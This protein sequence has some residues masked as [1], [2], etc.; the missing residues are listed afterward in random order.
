METLLILYRLFLML[1]VLSGPQFLGV[2]AYRA[3]KKHDD[4]RAHLLGLLIPPVLF[5]CF[6]WV[7]LN[8]SIKSIEANGERACGT[9]AGMMSLGILFMTGL[10][11]VF[12]IA[13]QVALHE[14]HRTDKIP[15]QA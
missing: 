5:F 6:S 9:Y 8:S 10:Q 2:L 4:F 14:K 11:A 7:M 15:R 13:V 12:G 3:I 1:G